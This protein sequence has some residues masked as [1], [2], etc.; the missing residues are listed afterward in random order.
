[1]DI[2]GP[3]HDVYPSDRAEFTGKSLI[4]LSFLVL[5]FPKQFLFC[6]FNELKFSI[7]I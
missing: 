5:S 3:E 4:D 6:C 1:M 2:G 7:Q